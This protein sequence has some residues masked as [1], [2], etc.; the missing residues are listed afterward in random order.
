M[1]FR[2][3]IHS[4]LTAIL[5]IAIVCSGC[6]RELTECQGP[7]LNINALNIL[8]SATPSTTGAKAFLVLPNPID[9]TGVR[10]MQANDSKA[11]QALS[12][13]FLPGMTNPNEL[14]NDFLKVRLHSMDDSDSILAEAL[15]GQFKYDLTDP[16]YTEVMAHY[17]ITTALQYMQ[18]LGF[19]LVKTRPLFVMTQF[20]EEAG[21]PGEVNAFYDHNYLQPDLPRTMK[22][23]GEGQYA[24]GIDRDIY[25]HEIGH[26]LNESISNETGMDFAGDAGA[27]FSEGS[28]LHECLADYI[29]ETLSNRPYVG[30]W[31]GRNFDD[32]PVGDPLRR[33]TDTSK[34]PRFQDV[35]KNDGSQSFPERY[36]VS[37]WCSRVL[38]D[39][40]TQFAKEDP[41]AGPALADRFI[42]SA[43]GMLKKDSSIREFKAALEQSDESLH[44]GLHKTSIERAFAGRGFNS[45]PDT[46]RKQLTVAVQARA[47]TPTANGYNAATM[48]AGATVGFDIKISNPNTVVARNVRIRLESKSAAFRTTT[49]QQGLGDLQGGV[50]LS[51]G[52]GGVLA[53]DY[54]VFGEWVSGATATSIPY[55]LRV[56]VENG[57]E[58]VIEGDLLK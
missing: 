41:S 42:F 35:V 11:L 26:Y 20:R 5:I 49:Y 28:A 54:S 8:K 24:P 33:A 45:N 18:V 2:R 3:L 13:L 38:W 9:A 12:S 36:K 34:S 32:V 30:R 39:L 43:V 51:I 25:W 50:L 53:L 44:C 6:A 37:E 22:V 31:I 19:S 7:K 1:N 4:P 16:H 55:R 40:R 27:V 48:K 10:T 57:P 14:G 46:L 47:V 52:T 29:A 58:T 23:S 56:L 17:S 15:N 21:K